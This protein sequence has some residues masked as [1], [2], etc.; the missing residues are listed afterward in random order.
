MWGLPKRL[1]R[2]KDFEDTLKKMMKEKEL[3]DIRGHLRD[4]M[5]RYG[6]FIK[7]EEKKREEERKREKEA[8][9]YLK[10]KDEE[11]TFFFRVEVWRR[12]SED[13]CKTVFEDEPVFFNF[14]EK[15]SQ[16]LDDV[17]VYGS[18]A[19]SFILFKFNSPKELDPPIVKGITGWVYDLLDVYKLNSYT[20]GTGRRDSIDMMV[21]CKEYYLMTEE[22]GSELKYRYKIL[23]GKSAGK[24]GE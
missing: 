17:L 4:E 24:R 16:Y 12:M 23:G 22:R 2:G 5:N 19:G 10:E 21:Y 6:R 11:H 7:D 14:L 3:A 9:L 13:L 18:P 20:T 1:E 8:L 15:F